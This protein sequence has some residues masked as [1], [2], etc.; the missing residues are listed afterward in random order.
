[1]NKFSI[2]GGFFNLNGKKVFLN[3]GEI[4][5]FRI[6]RE[7]WDEHLQKAKEAGLRTISSYVPWVWHEISEGYF[8]FNGTTQPE[9][10]LVGWLDL[11]QKYGF[12]SIVKPG[13]FILAEYRGAGLPDWFLEKYGNAIKMH[14]NKG[15]AVLSDGVSLFNPLFLSKVEQ[16][17][18]HVMPIIGQKQIH[19]GGPIIMMQVCNEIGVFSW[20][21]HQ[22]D[23][24]EQVK[25]Q[26]INF[27]KNRYSGIQE[28]NTL[29]ETN[30]SSFDDIELPPDGNSP[31]KS[32]GDRSRDYE[33]HCFWR[34]YY[35]NYLRLLSS[36][37]RKHQIWVP[38]YH[39][40]PG[41]I[42]G[43]GYEFPL[44]ITMYEDLYRDKS[45]LIFGVDHIPE[46]VS[47]RN[48]H[49]DRIINDIVSAMQGNKPL[50]AAEFQSGSRE[51]HV[52]T[53][54]RE[55]E[56]FYK[57]SIANGLK[58][59]N[60]YMF[61]QGKNPP[62]KGYS[63]DTF[64]WFTPL[65]YQANP[66]SAFP[67]V[68]KMSKFI[69]T[70]EE[71]I[72]NT[73]RKADICVL[74][75]SPY[76]ATELER[77]EEGASKLKFVPARI[78]RPAF[79]DGLLKVLQVLNIDYD[80][81]NL[82]GSSEND[83]AAY[84]QVWL[85]STDEMNAADQQTVAKYVTAGGN[86]V[87][88]PYLPDREMNQRPCTILRDAF[89]I[90]S[91]QHEVID[92]PLIKLFNLTDIKCSNPLITYTTETIGDATPIAFT[93]KGSICGFEKNVGK[94]KV[95][96]LGTWLGFDT[97][98]HKHAYK[99]ILDRSNAQKANATCTNDFIAVRQKFNDKSEALLFVGNYYNEN[100]SGQITYRHPKTSE[101]VQLPLI[102]GAIEIPPL[103]AFISP[104][105]KEISNSINILHTTSDVTGIKVND[106]SVLINLMG[107][108]KLLGE[109]VLEG[110][111]IT[112]IKSAEISGKPIMLIWHNNRIV[113]NYNHGNDEFELTLKMLD[114]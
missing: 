64:Y 71:L 74:F 111:N 63:G 31:Y 25:E 13:P 47:Y 107:D 38:L 96:H 89:N 109:M 73:K 40:L 37:I 18:N 48:L 17:Y 99:S 72:L 27:I 82:T 91:S 80:M 39:N 22:A 7:L 41:W 6:K 105:G 9:R 108:P 11:C 106:K 52:V 20:L 2:E 65:D 77:P 29:W 110:R 4:H 53:N 15:E 5:Y 49:D 93:L 12:T 84:K 103:Y 1:M 102:D 34:K 59:W 81:V 57:A 69:D 58:G 68:K 10:D 78:R 21:A 75:Y 61:S 112:K 42:Y 85:F 70:H 28:L 90:K 98:G 36:W 113:L 3:S 56:L 45:E 67:V 76:Y 43:H 32:K 14:N 46:F 79:F 44:N 54:P 51:Y 33:W 88:F 87:I 26:F 86:L 97:E 8:D 100:Q 101:I 104:V 50:F 24:N 114:K 62:A 66:S 83:L 94:G 95:I 35:G 60:Y 92:S 55:M 16:W 19:N 30:Y 23:Y